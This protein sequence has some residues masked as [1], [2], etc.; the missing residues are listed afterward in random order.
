M[1]EYDTKE[2]AYTEKYA[3]A[4]QTRRWYEDRFYIDSARL[5][6]KRKQAAKLRL[7]SRSGV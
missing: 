1:R 5:E 2:R 6:R 3:E 4:I 7:S